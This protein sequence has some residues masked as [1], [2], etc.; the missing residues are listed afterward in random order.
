[1]YD[2]ISLWLCLHVWL[3]VIVCVC[4]VMC[5]VLCSCSYIQLCVCGYVWLCMWLCVCGWNMTSYQSV[6][7][8]V[9]LIVCWGA[10]ISLA[11][12][13]LHP[14]EYLFPCLFSVALSE[15]HNFF[16]GH[17]GLS[18]TG[19]FPRGDSCS[20][21]PLSWDAQSQKREWAAYHLSSWAYVLSCSLDM[22]HCLP[23]QCWCPPQS[24]GLNLSLVEQRS[25]CSCQPHEMFHMRQVNRWLGHN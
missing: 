17:E 1:M 15:P 14:P 23:A 20:T 19:D 2:C 16:S 18:S 13:F 4:V 10:Q 7:Y 5:V 25:I 11:W 8:L 24:T 21:H 12:Q 3:C 6:W 22:E 9:L